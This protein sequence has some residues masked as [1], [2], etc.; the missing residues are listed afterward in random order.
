MKTEIKKPSYEV[1]CEAAELIKKGEVVAIPTETVYGLAA[2]AYNPDAC[3][4]IFK[5]KGRP[6]DNPL[7]IHICD[8]DMLKNS[9]KEIP[10]LALTLAE[11][12]WSG[13]LTMI[14][15]KK[16]IVPDTTSGGLDTVAVTVKNTYKADGTLVITANKA[17]E[18]V[19]GGK[20]QSDNGTAR[21]CRYERQNTAYNRRRRM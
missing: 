2:D 15:P 11:H 21:L 9:V 18:G 3:A 14:F 5:A 13:S 19:E 16:D 7:I 17:F 8:L 4:K 1:L 6:Q 12:F 20:P 10:P